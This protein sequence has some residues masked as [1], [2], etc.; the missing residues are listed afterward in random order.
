MA[1]FNPLDYPACLSYPARLPAHTDDSVY[2]P[3]MMFLIELL[4]PKV[5][6]ELGTKD[7]ASYCACCQTI[8]TLGLTTSCYS[9][10]AREQHDNSGAQV[11]AKLKQY[12]DPLY[13]GFSELTQKTFDAALMDFV[14]GEIDLLYIREGRSSEALKHLFHA[15]LPKM[16]DQGAVI[17]H[18]INAREHSG[19]AGHLWEEIKSLYP[20]FELPYRNGLGIISV[21]KHES[22]PLLSLIQLAEDD[23]SLLTRF[24]EGMG[25]RLEIHLKK[26]QQIK[27]LGLELEEKNLKIQALSLRLTKSQKNLEAVTEGWQVNYQTVLRKWGTKQKEMVEDKARAIQS[28][29]ATLA[30]ERKHRQQLLTELEETSHK[31]IATTTR[32]N[33]I[34]GSRAWR[35]VTRYGRMKAI[36]LT[37]IN[38]LF[39]RK[40]D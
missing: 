19:S 35:W 32:L 1:A 39:N 12:H 8:K 4:C 15:W 22:S 40:A 37:S 24:F 38:R 26:E 16:S 17:F 11:F 2:L 13:Q 34:L 10:N 7:G 31:L 5:F 28:L 20:H 27:S 21:S 30:R 18:N 6:V 23:A 14:D 9:I 3:F 25:R 36:L 33:N 29:S